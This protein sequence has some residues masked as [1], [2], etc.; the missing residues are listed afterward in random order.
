MK[1]F[2][3]AIA[4]IVDVNTGNGLPLATGHGEKVV[5]YQGSRRQ[6]ASKL[7]NYLQRVRTGISVARIVLRKRRALKRSL[8]PLSQL[9]DHLL[10]DIGLSRADV[11]AAE[12]GQ[13]DAAELE[14]RRIEN[15]GNK[16]INLRQGTATGDNPETR[17]AFNEAVFARAKC[18]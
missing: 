9:S 12:N 7:V 1:L 3:Y 14:S 15:R 13:I 5:D 4:S 2:Q 18:A 10:E 17:N 11:L 6:F 8:Q 16:R